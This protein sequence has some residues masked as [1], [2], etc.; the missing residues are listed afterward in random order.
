MTALGLFHTG[1]AIAALV[2]G[3]AVLL[4]RKGTRRH[5]QV[6]WLYGAGMIALN[7]RK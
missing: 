2:G 7:T 3:A 4:S 1:T 5:R 6:G